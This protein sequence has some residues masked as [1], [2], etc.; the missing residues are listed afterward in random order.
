MFLMF[1][2]ALFLK[3]VLQKSLFSG[4]IRQKYCYFML[5]CFRMSSI[6]SGYDLSVDTFSPDGRIFQVEYAM[7]AVENSSTVV[8][9]RC[10]DG[11]VLA[12]EKLIASSLHVQGDNSRIFKVCFYRL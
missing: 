9:L 3:S 7:K 1:S 6:G 2:P 5:K 10:V 8:G 12:T 11:V 4:I